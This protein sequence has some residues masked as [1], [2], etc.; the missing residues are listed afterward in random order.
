MSDLNGNAFE[1]WFK[2]AITEAVNAAITP[3]R[4]EVNARFD[5]VESDIAKNAVELGEVKSRLDTLESR[6]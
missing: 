1:Q 5:K 6:L 4:S 2:G 3:F